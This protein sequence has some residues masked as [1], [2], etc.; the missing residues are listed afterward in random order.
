VPRER[1]A[2]GDRLRAEKFGR[3]KERAKLDVVAFV[4][5]KQFFVSFLFPS[6][7]I[8]RRAKQTTTTTTT[9]PPKSGEAKEQEQEECCRRRIGRRFLREGRRRPSRRFAGKKGSRGGG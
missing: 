6:L 9:T 7:A 5:G 1:L 3:E 8:K 2:R 4:K